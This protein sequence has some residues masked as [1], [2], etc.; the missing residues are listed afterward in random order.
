MKCT[1]R[2]RQNTFLGTDK[3]LHG[4]T[5][6][7]MYLKVILLFQEKRKSLRCLYLI[8]PELVRVLPSCCYHIC[9]N[10]CCLYWVSGDYLFK[11]GLC[12]LIS[13]Q[14]QEV[15]GAKLKECLIKI[16]GNKAC[17]SSLS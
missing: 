1:L 7:F 3:F 13:K 15:M 17:S 9:C 12:K 16:N 5:V 2:L 14:N 10:I 11:E 4:V 8:A 6:T